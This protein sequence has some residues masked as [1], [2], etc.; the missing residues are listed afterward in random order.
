MF[1]GP[2]WHSYIRRVPGLKCWLFLADDQTIS[3]L[4]T[5]KLW[6]TKYQALGFSANPCHLSHRGSTPWNALLTNS[7]HKSEKQ[8]LL[9][10]QYIQHELCPAITECPLTL[11][12]DRNL[13]GHEHPRHRALLRPGSSSASA[14]ILLC[15]SVVNTEPLLCFKCDKTESDLKEKNISNSSYK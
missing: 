10:L 6:L 1:H 15:E 3:Q 7:I 11:T 2:A 8:S 5:N 4:S 9:V 12:C 14:T 13:I